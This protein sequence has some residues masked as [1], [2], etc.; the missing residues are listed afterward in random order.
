M[1]FC[2]LSGEVPQTPTV[3]SKSGHIYERRLIE[4]Y[5][6]ENGTDPI[7]GERLTEEDLIPIKTSSQAA[8]PR[9]A[10]LTSIPVI[11]HTLQNEWDALVLE[12]YTLKQQLN[13]VRQELSH[14]LYQCDAA[15]RVAARLLKERDTAREAL[16]SVQATLGAPPSDTPPDVEMPAGGPEQSG[17]LPVD[18]D[19]L[20]ADT[21]Q[22]CAALRH[23]EEKAK[24]PASY[25]T[26]NQI[27]N[28]TSK[29]TIP[30]LHSTS[31][32]GIAALA[33]SS[34]YPTQ[35]I[36]G[37][38]D[39]VVQVYDQETSKVLA[40]LKGHTKKVNHNL[41]P[42]LVISG[43]VDKTVRIWSHDSSS[44]DFAPA[45]TVKIHKGE[46]SG[47]AVHPTSTLLAVSSLDKSY[48]IHNLSTLQSIFHSSPAAAAYTSLSIHPDGA[49]LALGT[50]QS[51]IHIYDVRAAA[52]ANGFHLAFPDTPSTV[53]VWDLRKTKKV[54]SFPLS[55]SDGAYK[56][57]KV[58]Y[59]ASSQFLGVSGPDLRI[60]AHKT[61]EELIKLEGGGEI[62]DFAFGREAHNIW[63]AVGREV[64][65][66]A[67]KDQ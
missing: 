60:F 54:T 58:R 51:T 62:V 29:H 55:G 26:A 6:S 57:N 32:V 64:K 44:G 66:W 4:K 22:T 49:L 14:S 59:D 63:A 19:A 24:P 3:S 35:F 46:I 67:E 16:A 45:H 25:A 61:W 1:L 9:P 27:R 37:G 50:S 11:L 21:Q 20:I 40:T 15:T 18:V 52:L 2:A 30:S 31:P 47:V 38:N 13:A 10:T 12:Q 65:I 5:I 28:F 7:T 56:I 17:P 34:V 41:K 23:Q 48:S 39:N 42:R 53:S 8:P 33:V 43:S 36:T